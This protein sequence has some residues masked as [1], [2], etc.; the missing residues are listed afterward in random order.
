MFTEEEIALMDADLQP[1][2]RAIIARSKEPVQVRPE[3]LH[4]DKLL[5]SDP[6]AASHAI[7]EFMERDLA[8]MRPTNKEDAGV[9]VTPR[10]DSK[11]GA[12]AAAQ[13]DAGVGPSSPGGRC[14]A[15]RQKEEEEDATDAALGNDADR[16][17]E[18]VKRRRLVSGL[19]PRCGH[20]VRVPKI[21]RF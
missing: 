8:K 16:P 1:R 12:A 13:G 4:I 5:L 20:P 19:S 11:E 9:T 6:V 3:I 15:D 10:R 21:Q 14:A 2:V 17:H 18:Q 7:W